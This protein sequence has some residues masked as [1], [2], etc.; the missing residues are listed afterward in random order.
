PGIVRDYLVRLNTS[1]LQLCQERLD[2]SLVHLL[3]Q[4]G[5]ADQSV[6]IGG[7]RVDRQQQRQL[8]LVDLIDAQ[9]AREAGDHPG[10]VVDSKVQLIGKGSAPQADHLLARSH[11]EVACQAIGN[12]AGSETVEIDRLDGFLDNS[13]GIDRVWSKKGRL[14]AKGT[15]AGQTPM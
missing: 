15:S 7:R 1:R 12:T 4:Q 11:P 10:L 13:P 9:N 6:T 8:T 14:R 5:V 2:R 3:R